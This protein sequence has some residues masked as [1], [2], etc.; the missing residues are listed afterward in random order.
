LTKIQLRYSRLQNFSDILVQVTRG[1]PFMKTKEKT[2]CGNIYNK[3][4]LSDK[5]MSIDELL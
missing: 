3:P 4:K 2:D 5:L 1:F